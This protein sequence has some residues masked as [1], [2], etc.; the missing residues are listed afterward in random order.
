MNK[1]SRKGINTISLII[2]II[3]FILIN[4]FFQSINFASQQKISKKE[5]T[6]P[7]QE[8]QQEVIQQETKQESQ[9]EEV[10]E[11][12]EWKIEIPIIS[13]EAPIAEG[14]DNA[15]MDKYVGHFEETS[16]IEGN[17]GLA[18]H[19]RGYPV[20]Y[21]AKIKNLKK[22]DEIHYKYNGAEKIYE[23]EII[24]VIKDTDWTYL[25]NTQANKITLITCVEDAPMYRRCIQAIE[26]GG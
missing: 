19:N 20:N 18:A 14:T 10:S 3:I 11:I 8:V 4:L 21:F 12:K 7:S 5:E 13:L 2:S 1:Y 17:V 16:K 15:T 25:E 22:G 9:E 26:K 23:V 24:K 6:N